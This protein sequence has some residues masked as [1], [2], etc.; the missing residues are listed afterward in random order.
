MG[1]TIDMFIQTKSVN[2]KTSVTNNYAQVAVLGCDSGKVN[3][4]Y[5][6]Q[7]QVWLEDL[8]SGCASNE[9]NILEFCQK[10]TISNALIHNLPDD[11]L[12]DFFPFRFIHHCKLVILF[13]LMQF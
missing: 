11:L 8:V 9:Q 7:R 13:D 5:D 3:L 1:F 2:L 10:V 4:Y 12:F 6:M